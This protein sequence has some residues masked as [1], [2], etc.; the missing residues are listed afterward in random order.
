MTAGSALSPPTKGPRIALRLLE[1]TDLH[2]HIHGYDYYTDRPSDAVGLARLTSQIDAARAEAANCLLF[3]NGDFLQG[4]ALTEYWGRERGLSEGETHPM[5][6]AMNAVGYDAGTPGNHEF[7]YGL[8]FMMRALAGADFPM[9]CANAITEL[10]AEP[11]RDRTLLPPWVIL[12]RPMRDTAGTEHTL[13]IG[14]IGLLPPQITAWDRQHLEGRLTTRGIVEA[15]RAHVPAL[16]AAG[17]DLVVALAHT[18]ISPCEEDTEHA[19]LALAR[20]PGIDVLLC[21]HSHLCFPGPETHAAP[22]IDPARGTLHGKPAMLAGRWGSHLGVMDLQLQQTPDG[23]H[24]AD[25]TTELRP[26]HPAAGPPRPPEA[27]R[28]IATN[29]AAHAETLAFARRPVGHSAVALHSY[30]APVAPDRALTLVAQAQRN[31]V[32]RCMGGDLPILSAVSPFKCGGRSGPEH[33]LDIPPGPLTTRHIVDLYLFPNTVSA[34]EVTGADLADWLE[35]A[36]GLFCRLSPGLQDQPLLNPDFP[37]YNFDVILGL[38]YQIDLSQPARYALDGRLANADVRRIGEICHAGKPVAPDDRFILA[39]N[40][41]RSSGAGGFVA[42]GSRALDLGPPMA[43]QDALMDAVRSTT[44]IAPDPEPIWRF[45]P[46]PGT[47]A[48]YRTSPRAARFLPLSPGPRME[49]LGLAEDGFLE[50][51]L[52]F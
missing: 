6:A 21:G 13:R 7:N 40:N 38:T 41:Y 15:A 22:G 33:F 29:T 3:D 25:F 23:W 17:A 8:D 4:T 1:T 12:T 39:T 30:F 36:A 16:R 48:I 32:R 18:G 34:I 50:I 37:C 14:I 9:V 51:R 10:G 49:P 35:R 45:A 19:A 5:I 20:V 44:S 24:I 42:E 2:G 47:P 46:L 43:A 31:H 27:P 11:P 28:I 52:H 26:I